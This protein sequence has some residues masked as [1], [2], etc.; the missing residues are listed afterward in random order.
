VHND[1]KVLHIEHLIPRNRIRD[2]SKYE[3][4]K[5]MAKLTDRKT[6]SLKA[7]TLALFGK[8]YIFMKEFVKLVCSLVEVMVF[9][10]LMNKNVISEILPY[11]E[12][13]MIVWQAR[14]CGLSSEVELLSARDGQC[15]FLHVHLEIYGDDH[16][17]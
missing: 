17:I 3:P 6:A 7:L 14:A 9:L 16:M 10:G 15:L 1:L 2:T 5:Q 12:G 8:F 4:L 11:V 13:L